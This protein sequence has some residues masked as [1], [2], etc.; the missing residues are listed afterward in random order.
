MKR[1][2][3]AGNPD[4]SPRYLRPATDVP[5]GEKYSGK[6]DG[7]LQGA[8]PKAWGNLLLHAVSGDCDEP[9]E[10]VYRL[11]EGRRGPGNRRDSVPDILL[12]PHEFVKIYGQEAAERLGLEKIPSD[13]IHLTPALFKK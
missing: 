3:R 8:A 9:W 11:D 6:R 4:D 5:A 1:S 7:D 2:R 13:S 10:R 12:R